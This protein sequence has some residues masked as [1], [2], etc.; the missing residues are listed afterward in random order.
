[1]VLASRIL[2]LF[3]VLWLDSWFGLYIWFCWDLG[4]LFQSIVKGYYLIKLF[5]FF[6]FNKM[7]KL[8]QKYI[9]LC[10]FF[11]FIYIKERER[12]QNKK[13]PT[14]SAIMFQIY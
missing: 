13:Y 14:I 8:N 9:Y 5:S 7:M 12:S 2:L 4:K 1:M 10:F 11:W 3:F 6:L